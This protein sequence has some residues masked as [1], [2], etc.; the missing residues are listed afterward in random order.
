MR[1][2]EVELPMRVLEQ[3][4]GVLKEN[5]GICKMGDECGEIIEKVVLGGGAIGFEFG[6]E[7]IVLDAAKQGVCVQIVEIEILSSMKAEYLKIFEYSDWQSFL[8]YN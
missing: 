4:Y 7:A 6:E 2:I 5:G 8:K 3:G 1:D